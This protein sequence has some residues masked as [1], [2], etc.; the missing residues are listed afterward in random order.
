MIFRP[1]SCMAVSRSYPRHFFTFREKKHSASF[2][3]FA[4]FSFKK[5]PTFHRNAS[6][7]L[8]LVICPVIR[9]II[10]CFDLMIS[11]DLIKSS[12]I[13]IAG[14]EPKCHFLLKFLD[15]KMM[16]KKFQKN[17]SCHYL[18]ILTYIY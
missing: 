6:F 4:S 1:P 3:S 16:E 14:D 2:F 5:D 15:C 12:E 17:F 7:L 11:L 9:P 10:L 18:I 13:R 8:H